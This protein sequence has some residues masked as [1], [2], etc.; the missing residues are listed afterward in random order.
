[1]DDGLN[2]WSLYSNYV[3]AYGMADECTS[4]GWGACV[5]SNHN[6]LRIMCRNPREFKVW[7][8]SL[9]LFRH[10]RKHYGTNMSNIYNIMV[11]TVFSIFKY[12]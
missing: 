12:S 3:H 9:G 2:R 11:F 4:R 6:F 5:C 8:A 7:M 10:A 1:M